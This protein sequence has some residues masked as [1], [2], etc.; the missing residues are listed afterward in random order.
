MFLLH[1]NS[2]ILILL[3]VGGMNNTDVS[4]KSFVKPCFSGMIANICIHLGPGIGSFVI[5]LHRA[6]NHI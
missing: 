3:H 6:T 2:L 4:I 1:F 5:Q